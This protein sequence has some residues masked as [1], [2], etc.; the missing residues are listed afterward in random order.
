VSLSLPATAR[1]RQV[2]L[3]LV[4]ALAIFPV[5]GHLSSRAFNWGVGDFAVWWLMVGAL[6]AALFVMPRMVGTRAGLSLA[7][8]GVAV[9]FLAVWAELAVGIFD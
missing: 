2:T 6:A 9:V 3:A 1:F 5:I 4:A 7:V 8:M